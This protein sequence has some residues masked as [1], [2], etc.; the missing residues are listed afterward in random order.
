[1]T[2]ERVLQISTLILSSV[3]LMIKES[4]KQLQI[5]IGK[6]IRLLRESKG[7][8]QQNFAHDCNIEKSNYHRI[9]AGNTN[10]TIYTLKVIADNLNVTLEDI[11]KDI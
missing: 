11:V 3:E 5:Q 2:I 9:E 10:P 1:M 4:K 6:R 7:F 8:S